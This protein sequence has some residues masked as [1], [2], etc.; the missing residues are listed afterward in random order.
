M[1]VVFLLF[2][3]SA[4]STALPS[5]VLLGPASQLVTHR[6][7]RPA[8]GRG[9]TGE[10]VML[11]DRW[12]LSYCGAR[13][14]IFRELCFPRKVN[15][16]RLLSLISTPS[17]PRHLPLLLQLHQGICS[18]AEGGR[19]GGRGT[20]GRGRRRVERETEMMEVRDF[21]EERW[22]GRRREERKRSSDKV[23]LKRRVEVVGMKRRRRKEGA[24]E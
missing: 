7:M 23:R 11:W 13:P 1:S 12:V 21:E 9:R 15:T 6:S 2:L 10:R 8:G 16:S 20:G 19:G 4:G 5:V 24:N 18:P 14:L 3:G 22:R 17:T